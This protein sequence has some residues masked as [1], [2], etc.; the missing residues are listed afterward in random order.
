LAY[1]GTKPA[2]NAT[3]SAMAEMTTLFF[4]SAPLFEG[5]P[6]GPGN[7]SGSGKTSAIRGPL[8]ACAVGI[9]EPRASRVRIPRLF[10]RAAP[11]SSPGRTA[12]RGSRRAGVLRR[13]CFRGASRKLTRVAP[14]PARRFEP[15]AAEVACSRVPRDRGAARGAR[16]NPAFSRQARSYRRS[17]AGPRRAGRGDSSRSSSGRV[18]R[19]WR[20][21]QGAA[22]GSARAW[23]S[24]RRPGA[25]VDLGTDHDARPAA[26]ASAGTSRHARAFAGLDVPSRRLVQIRVGTRAEIRPAR[27]GVTW[28][29]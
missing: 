25:V 6:G 13:G 8:G 21:D 16:P 29:I 18:G 5:N 7:D 4:T 3:T 1:C 9:E 26:R 27:R 11:S 23:R 15:L 12:T 10:A 20:R 19:A 28:P 22:R 14:D 24:G 17:R 2:R